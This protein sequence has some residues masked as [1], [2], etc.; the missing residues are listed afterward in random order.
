MFKPRTLFPSLRFFGGSVVVLVDGVATSVNVE[1]HFRWLHAQAAKNHP[2]ANGRGKSRRNVADS[3][4][5]GHELASAAFERI[6]T[7]HDR[8]EVDSELRERGNERQKRKPVDSVAAQGHK[9]KSEPIRSAYK[10]AETLGVSGRSVA[11]A[12]RITKEGTPELVK[13]I[14]D[15]NVA[16]RPAENIV[17]LPKEEQP[18]ALADAKAKKPA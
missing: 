18:Q 17:R 3:A 7:G 2:T 4:F 16:L 11:R 5:A 15:G 13:A 9:Q 8:R 6:A 1:G 14:E 12:K 10:V